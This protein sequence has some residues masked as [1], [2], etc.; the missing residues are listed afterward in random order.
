MEKYMQSIVELRKIRS[1]LIYMKSDKTKL[2]IED[3]SLLP[4][5]TVPFFTWMAIFILSED[6]VKAK[7][8]PKRAIV[9]FLSKRN[10]INSVTAMLV[11]E[12]LQFVQLITD[13]F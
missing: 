3:R 9:T 13:T 5:E 2:V 11:S 7:N 12:K 6:R 4:K 8:A 10:G 1:I